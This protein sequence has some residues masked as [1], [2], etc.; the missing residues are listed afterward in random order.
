MPPVQVNISDLTYSL[1][2][3]L[4]RQLGVE[5]AEEGIVDSL[6]KLGFWRRAVRALPLEDERGW[7]LANMLTTA[8]LIALGAQARTE[9]RG[10]HYRTDHP[11]E[12]DSWC[13]HLVQTPIRGDSGVVGMRLTKTFLG[14][15][16]PTP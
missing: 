3:L 5:R 7:E 2:S 12:N 16:I 14:E 8:S 11:E 6:E 10:V 9:S 1:K 4:W 13:A 15:G